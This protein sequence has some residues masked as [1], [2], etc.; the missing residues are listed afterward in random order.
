MSSVNHIRNGDFKIEKQY[1][2]HRFFRGFFSPDMRFRSTE[3][4]TQLPLFNEYN[5]LI[6]GRVVVTSALSTQRTS[7]YA[8]L[9]ISK[10]P[11]IRQLY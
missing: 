4:Q 5:C 9:D 2:V 10:E 1:I 11:L 8:D 3:H 6:L 7:N